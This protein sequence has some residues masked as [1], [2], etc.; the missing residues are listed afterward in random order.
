MA[1][2]CDPPRIMFLISSHTFSYEFQSISFLEFSSSI[3]SYSIHENVGSPSSFFNILNLICSSPFLSSET[4]ALKLADS[5][6]SLDN[7][8]LEVKFNLNYENNFCPL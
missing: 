7:S 3:E 8:S 5:I 2:T 6:I 1:R 4:Q